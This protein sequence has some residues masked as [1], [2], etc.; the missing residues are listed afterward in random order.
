MMRTNLSQ[1]TGEKTM[2]PILQ[3]VEVLAPFEIGEV[4]L[5]HSTI[6]F[7]QPLIL[8]P[9]WLPD[10]PDEPDDSEY[11]L[12]DHPELG[13]HVYAENRDDLLEF[14]YS[15]L[16]FVWQHYVL[17]DDE[18]LIPKTKSIKYHYLKIAEMINE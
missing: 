7:F 15:D 17:V 1:K 8:T 4:T 3:E 16:R 6:K 14:I 10:D 13:I 9:T 11:L 12:I 5:D 18:K 2:I